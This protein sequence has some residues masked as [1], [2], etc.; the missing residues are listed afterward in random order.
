MFW[1]RMRDRD[2]FSLRNANSY[3]YVVTLVAE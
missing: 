1:K 3:Y 2:E